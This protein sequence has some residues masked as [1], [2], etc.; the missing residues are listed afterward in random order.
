MSR[1]TA[2]VVIKVQWIPGVHANPAEWDWIELIDPEPDE[3]E[4]TPVEV[5]EHDLYV[6]YARYVGENLERIGRDG[7]VPL[8]FEEFRRS[9]EGA[10]DYA[11]DLNDQN[12]Y[13]Y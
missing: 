12:P 4:G 7:W 6:A 10:G 3:N 9:E 8:C 13:N 5:V 11:R 1:E 2:V